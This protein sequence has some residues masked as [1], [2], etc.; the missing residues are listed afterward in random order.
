MFK[1]NQAKPPTTDKDKSKTPSNIPADQQQGWVRGWINV[2]K[3]I[4]NPG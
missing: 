1:L 4:Q 3:I 2:D